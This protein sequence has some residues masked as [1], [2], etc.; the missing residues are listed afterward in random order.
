MY[1]LRRDG[2]FYDLPPGI[3]LRTFAMRLYQRKYA[4]SNDPS[5]TEWREHLVNAELRLDYEKNC[6]LYELI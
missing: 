1:M 6:S 2:H 3:M 5:D 4:E